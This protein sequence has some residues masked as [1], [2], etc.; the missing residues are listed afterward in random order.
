LI[1]A[2]KRDNENADRLLRRFNRS[3]QQSGLLANV[4][5]KRYF[6][7]TVSKSIQ[8]KSAIRKESVREYKRMK[9]EGY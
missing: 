2:T 9:K 8:R 6:E 7:K 3:V 4:K 5:K 1:E